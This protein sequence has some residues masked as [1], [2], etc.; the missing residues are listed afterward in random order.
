MG[1]NINKPTETTRPTKKQK[2]LLDF[3]SEFISQH[4]YSPSYREIKSGLNYNSVATVALHINS[5]VARGHLIKRD[6][7]A[8]SL[9]PVKGAEE[10]IKTNRVT[11]KEEKWLVKK[12]EYYFMTAEQEQDPSQDQIN[13]LYVLVGALKILG[14]DGASQSFISRLSSLK[15]SSKR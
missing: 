2:A 14:F 13:Q 6:H 9:E 10:S 5:L 8:R 15:N 11:E 12:I 3:I 7:S 4:G 1:S